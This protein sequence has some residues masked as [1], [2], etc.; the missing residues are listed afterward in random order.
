[1][2]ASG[3]FARDP[4]VLAGLA[5]AQF[6]TSDPA[7]A[8][9]TLETLFQVKADARRQPDNALL[10]ARALAATQ[11]AGTREAFQAALAVAA[12]PEPKCRF[13]DW[14]L[15]QGDVPAARA[16]YQEIVADSRHW[17]NHARSLNKE[18]LKRAETALAQ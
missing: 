8:I 12:D 9:A 14:L 16:L 18:W 4:A 2:A 6:S 10:Y 5:Q 13:A 1:E 11:H 15:A 7:G 3:P 17:H